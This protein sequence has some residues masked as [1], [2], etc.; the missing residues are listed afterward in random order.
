MTLPRDQPDYEL[1]AGNQRFRRPSVRMDPKP[2]SGSRRGA[3]PK[4]SAVDLVKLMSQ[5][6]S[7]REKVAQA[8]LEARSR[9]TLSIDGRRQK[10]AIRKAK[11]E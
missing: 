2:I 1:D 4:T 5:M 11:S 3:R 10:L 7:L 9:E 8:E 6:I